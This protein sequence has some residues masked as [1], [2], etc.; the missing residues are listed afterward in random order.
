MNTRW[1]EDRCLVGPFE[2]LTAVYLRKLKA[3]LNSV[4]QL[5]AG[6]CVS[7]PDLVYTNQISNDF[8]ERASFSS[9][10]ISFRREREREVTMG[11]DV[12]GEFC[13]RWIVGG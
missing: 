10:E 4:I 8:L 13:R 3:W 7:P 9:L 6:F 1:G 11:V 5:A 12:E 2:I